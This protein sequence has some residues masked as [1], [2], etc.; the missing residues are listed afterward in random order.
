MN[1]LKT[2]DDV[3]L[4][5]AGGSPGGKSAYDRTKFAAILRGET[6]MSI[7]AHNVG[8]AEA[9]LGASELERL[10]HDTAAPF[11]TTNLQPAGGPTQLPPLRWLEVGGRRLVVLG[12]LSPSLCPPGWKAIDP[13]TAVINALAPLRGGY[14]VPIVLAYLTT[15]ELEAFAAAMPEVDF[16]IG[17]PTRQTIAPRR[18]GP[19][20]LAAATNKGKF[21]V[22]FRSMPEDNR[23]WKAS[24]VEM[25]ASFADDPTQKA[26]VEGFEHE[27]ARRDFAPAD[28]SFAPALKADRPADYKVVGVESCRACH[29]DACRTWDQN[30][31]ARAWQT[32]V[33]H[34]RQFDSFCQQC[35]TT[36][37]GLPGG[38]ETVAKSAPRVAVGCESCHGPGAAHAANPEKKTAFAARDQCLTCHDHENS[39]KFDFAAY[40]ERIRH[41]N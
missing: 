7:A 19:T 1:G 11:V 24:V 33:D 34:H 36:G 32:L 14:D 2:T 8:A 12:V 29:A 20:W 4:L 41:G 28:T 30:G 17:G 15:A 39:P 6:A 22:Q 38:F 16:V 10:M 23:E 3:V 13:R 35:H 27:L 40:W 18:I 21:L 31:H 5:D 25:S 26:N 9:A 37:Y